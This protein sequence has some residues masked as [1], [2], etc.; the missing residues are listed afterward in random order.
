MY[1]RLAIALVAT[2]VLM[3]AGW[4]CYVAGQQAVQARWDQEK[5]VTLRAQQAKQQADQATADRIATQVAKSAARDRVVYRTIT[6]EAAHVP[7]DCPVP[8]LVRVLHDAAAAGEMPDTGAA[9]A[10][11]PAVSAQ[12]LVEAVSDNYQACRDDQRRLAALQQLIRN[13]NGQ[14]A[15]EWDDLPRDE[16][17]K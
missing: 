6:R 14:E 12:A 11:A 1:L 4:K 16:H 8:G 2:I 9:G 10:D 3:G 17:T 5:L 15:P 13:F 7:N